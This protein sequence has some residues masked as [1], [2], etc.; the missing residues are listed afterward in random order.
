MLNKNTVSSLNIQCDSKF[1]NECDGLVDPVDIS[2][3]KFK[4][5]TSITSIN[6]NISLQKFSKFIKLILIAFWRKTRNG[7]FRDTLYKCLKLSSNEIAL[8][9]LHI[10]NHQIIDQ[11]IFQSLLKLADV[12]PVFKKGDPQS[13]KNYRPVSVLPNV[14]KVFE[15]TTLKQ[16]LEEMNKYSS[17]NLCRYRKIL[18]LTLL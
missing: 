15:R 17:H 9:L 8:H 1:V 3:Q 2:I 11:N 6:E 4:N 13:I 18:V 14:S 10:W 12:T 16:I 7:T 5:Y